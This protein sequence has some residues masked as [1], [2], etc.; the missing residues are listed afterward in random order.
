MTTSLIK[1]EA[2]KNALNDHELYQIIVSHR[3]AFSKVSGVDY[4]LHNPKTLNPTP[5][6]EIIDTWAAGYQKM[7]EEMIYEEKPPKFEHLLESLAEVKK[8]LVA[9]KWDYQLR[10]ENAK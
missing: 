3:F 8:R 7:L 1:T 2:A 6:K 4:N 5:P 10:F 9:L